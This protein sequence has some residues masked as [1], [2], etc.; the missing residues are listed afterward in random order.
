MKSLLLELYQAFTW[1]G[2]QTV[3]MVIR[4]RELWNKTTHEVQFY[5]SSLACDARVIA[6]AMGRLG[7]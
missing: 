6:Q 2:L 1:A 5:L 7:D 4:V 3:V